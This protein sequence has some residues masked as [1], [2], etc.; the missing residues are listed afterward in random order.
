MDDELTQVDVPGGRIDVRFVG[1]GPTALFLHGLL[2]NGH[3]WDP[4]I[5]GLSG[6]LRM[7][8]P[9]LPLGGHRA[10]LEPDADC[11]LEAHAA[12]VVR[13][14]RQL[15]RPIVLVGSDTGGAIA[16]I[17]VAREPGLFDRLVLLP[18]DAFDNCPP[19]LL[20]PLRWL[21]A[22]PGAVGAVAFSLRL[23]MV[24][25]IMMSLVSR[26]RSDDAFLDELAGDLRTDRGVRRDL[27]KLLRNLRPEVTGAVADEL[28]QFKRP[29]LIAWSKRDP[30]FPLDHAERLAA[31]FGRASVV[32]AERSRAF[33]SVDEPE[34]LA[35]R[36]LDFVAVDEDRDAG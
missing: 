27:R 4:L 23:R 26:R 13:L 25:R 22:V 16:Q 31:C 33:I 30:L 15:P 19:K 24:M 28:L 32:L 5:P 20:V 14:A 29:V 1:R 36:I 8:L 12:R 10:A 17:A 9:D 3:V 34:W 18:S 11:S 6:R 7:V 35:E 21:A 2:V